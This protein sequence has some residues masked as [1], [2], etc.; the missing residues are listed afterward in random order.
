MY[1]LRPIW[2]AEQLR[3]NYAGRYYCPDPGGNC[4]LYFIGI[5]ALILILTCVISCVLAE[6]LSRKVMKRDNTIFDLSA[7]VTG[8][9][10]AFNL[11]ATINPLIA[12]L[13]A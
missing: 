9:L 12:V 4:I 1:R 6:Y 3:K 2:G 13:E 8:L 5:Q 10:L 7:V 11:P